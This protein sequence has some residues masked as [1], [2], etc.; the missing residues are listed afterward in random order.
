MAPA[1]GAAFPFSTYNT[2]AGGYAPVEGGYNRGTPLN[3]SN[4][5]EN[6]R[7]QALNDDA[8]RLIARLVPRLDDEQL[9]KKAVLGLHKS[10]LPGIE[11]AENRLAQALDRYLDKAS[12]VNMD[13]LSRVRSASSQAKD[14]ANGIRDMYNALELEDANLHW[15]HFIGFSPVCFLM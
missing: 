6:D 3:G 5:I 15:S 2:P 13:V 14:W 4:L 11:N 7:A 1:Q 9:D 8:N 12:T 10:K